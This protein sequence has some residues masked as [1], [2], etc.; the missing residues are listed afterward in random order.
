MAFNNVVRADCVYSCWILTIWMTKFC[1]QSLALFAF[2]ALFR[3]GIETPLLSFTAGSTSTLMTSAEISPW[4]MGDGYRHVYLDLGTNIGVQIRKLFEPE[5]YP[6]AK[7]HKFFDKWFEVPEERKR[8]VCAIGFEPDPSHTR[9][10]QE[11]ESHYRRRGY[12]VRIFTET[13]I[14]THDGPISLYQDK[15]VK[16]QRMGSSIVHSFKNDHSVRPVTKVTSVNVSKLVESISQRCCWYNASHM[17]KQPSIVMKMDIEGAEYRAIPQLIKT[18]MIC[19]LDLVFI[20]WH[21]PNKKKY[22]HYLPRASAQQIESNLRR[23]I[24][25]CPQPPVVSSL[26]DESYWMDGKPLHLE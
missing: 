11:V 7:I 18:G 13:A 14:G 3:A 16:H 19:H 21:R 22:L 20:E 2:S 17:S 10:L 23:A 25:Q 9:R 12:C 4:N 1:I 24:L 6:D 5:L 15:D 8:A 26:D